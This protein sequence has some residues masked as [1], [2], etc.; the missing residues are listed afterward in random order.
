MRGRRGFTLIE[1]LVVIAIIA[2]LAAMLLPA[3]AQARER[4]R[5]ASCMSNLKQI[6][7]AMFMYVEDNHGWLPGVMVPVAAPNWKWSEVL[8]GRNRYT[9]DQILSWVNYVT[10]DVMTCPTRRAEVGPFGSGP[11]HYGYNYNPGWEWRKI[12]KYETPSATAMV[13]DATN[14]WGSCPYSGAA[15]YGSC[16]LRHSDGANVLFFEGHVE[17][18]SEKDERMHDISCSLWVGW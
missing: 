17:R 16:D 18:I 13:F 3:L 15:P 7:L 14:C 10:M 8:S 9:G 12:G 5:T 6:G 2:I 1:L 11:D 4:A